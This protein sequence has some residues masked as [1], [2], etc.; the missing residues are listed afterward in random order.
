MTRHTPPH[1]ETQR[2]L[3]GS[4]MPHTHTQSHTTTNASCDLSVANVHNEHCLKRN[5][6]SPSETTA[7]Y[8]RDLATNH[9]TETVVRLSATQ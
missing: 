9:F 3:W 5:R 2:T 4:V 7:E 8:K 1:K 6:T